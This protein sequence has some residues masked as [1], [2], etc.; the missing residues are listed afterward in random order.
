MADFNDYFGS[1]LLSLDLKPR[2]WLVENIIRVKDSVILVGNEKS[3]KSLFLLQLIFALT[4]QH[5]FLDK[6]TVTRPC[7]ITYVQLEGE[8]NDTQDRIKRMMKTHSIELENFLLR[9]LAPLELQ[10]RGTTSNFATQL[11][12]LWQGAKPDI[13][14]FDPIYFAFT[15]SLSDDMV[16]RKFIGNIRTLKERLDCAIILVHHTHKS[17][18]DTNGKPIDEGD[19][20]L[21]GSKFLKAWADHILMFTYDAKQDI[22][23]LSCTTQRSGD[24]IKQCNL[25][26]IEPN[27]LYFE[28]TNNL[29]GS[30]EFAVVDL[31][32]DSGK[33]WTVDE[34]AENL[35]MSKE[36]VYHSIKRPLSQNIITKSVN[37]RPVYYWFNIEKEKSG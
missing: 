9:F 31:L 35:N 17:K 32:K 25:K 4:S 21:F 14:I 22:R 19:E 28:I 20:A 24:I 33:K 34:M 5:P 26:L 3:G 12:N 18:W 11:I 27:P 23:T 30:K 7:K 37:S 8:I 36:T 6:Y 29:T 10:D 13:V 2:E 15:G 16:V 1:Q